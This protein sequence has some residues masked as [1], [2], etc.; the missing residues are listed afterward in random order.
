L[1]ELDSKKLEELDIKD[2]CFPLSDLT[3]FGRFI[4]LK[5]L[6]LGNYNI[7]VSTP[8]IRNHFAGSLEPLQSLTK[9]EVLNIG[10]TDVNFE[11]EYL[12][13]S[14]KGFYFNEEKLNYKSRAIEQE[15]RKFGEPK[16]EKWMGKYGR[17][18]NFSN[19]LEL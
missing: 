15:L 16:K 7:K 1:S 14:V 4:N 12:P 11:L 8:H 2:N 10:N 5:S 18:Y 13:N 3:S 19:L 6:E 9:L 17:E